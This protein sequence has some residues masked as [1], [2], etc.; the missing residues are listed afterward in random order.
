MTAPWRPGQT[1]GVTE[2]DE[3]LDEDGSDYYPSGAA[4]AYPCLIML[5][6]GGGALLFVVLY[7]IAV[8]ARGL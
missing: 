4:I 7:A 3:R 8:I 5:I 6:L 1:E 2:M